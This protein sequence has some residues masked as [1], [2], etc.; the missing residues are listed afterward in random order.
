M[1]V[2]LIFILKI[3]LVPALIGAITLAVRRWGDIGVAVLSGIPIIIG[4]ILLILA[5]EHGKLF[6]S[7]S[8]LG[9]IPAVLANLSFGLSYTWAAI[10]Y[11]PAVSLL[12]GFTGFFLAV[13]ALSLID[14]PAY[15]VFGISL[16]GIWIAVRLFPKDAGESPPV[17]SIK[18][19]VWLR[20]AVGGILVLASTYLAKVAGPYWAGTFALFP[21]L[22]S[23]FAYFTHRYSGPGAC[24][25][26]MRSIARGFYAFL[27][28]CFV[29]AN[30]LPA[31]GI[32]TG[33]L[34]ALGVTLV[35]H[36]MLLWRANHFQFQPARSSE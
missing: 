9:A 25:R 17:K 8:A 4:P 10:R 30:F 11:S 27:S 7:Q 15:S 23:V 2:D 3:V 1:A 31:M 14:L 24:I 21:A 36:A 22:S 13:A 35:I 34:F 6:A 26:L 32:F 28:F 18:G 16:L 12:A 20:M 19:E 5:L 33:F 29:V